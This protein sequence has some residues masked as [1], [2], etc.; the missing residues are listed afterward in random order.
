[1]LPALLFI[2]VLCAF[3]W[4]GISS[5]W[6][7][8]AQTRP[9]S[10]RRGLLARNRRGALPSTVGV[11]LFLGAGWLLFIFG[12]ENRAI[13]GTPRYAADL[14]ILLGLAFVACSIIVLIT[15][16]PRR[17]VP[18]S[19]RSAGELFQRDSGDAAVMANRGLTLRVGEYEVGTFFAN[20]VQGNQ[21]YGGRLSITS[22]RLVFIP[23]AASQANGGS[24]TEFDLRKVLLAEVASRGSGPRGAGSLRRRLRV[25]TLSGD[26]E[27]FVVWR[28]KKL[29]GFVNG[30]L[31]GAGGSGR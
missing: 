25:R 26:A 1:M 27:Y 24:R 20:H 4:L 3:C 15:G 14:L 30:V 8:G 10:R 28:P 19:Q 6:Q 23:V 9:G 2:S 29:A 7:P 5:A 22:E 21:G 31:Q 16:R 11:T 17:M 12:K 18:P 13:A